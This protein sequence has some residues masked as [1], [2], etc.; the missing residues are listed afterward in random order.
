MKLKLNHEIVGTL[1]KVV[2][3]KNQ[4]KL[5]F[6]IMKEIVLPIDVVSSEKLDTFLDQRIGIINIDGT[7]K[8]RNI[9]TQCKYG[10]DKQFK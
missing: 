2:N 6:N 3:E 4:I 1:S 10:G 8:I 7:Y 5:I 9:K